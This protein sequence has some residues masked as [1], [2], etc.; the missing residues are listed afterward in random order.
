M[1]FVP[2]KSVQR[3]ARRGLELR[4]KQ[5]ASNRAGTSG[6]LARARDLA[7]GMALSLSTV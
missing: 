3:A 2:P 4:A 1:S 5:P 6:G 7:N